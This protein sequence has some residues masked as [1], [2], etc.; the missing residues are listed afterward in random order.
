MSGNFAQK[1]R[2]DY[3]RFPATCWQCPGQTGLPAVGLQGSL[4]STQLEAPRQPDAPYTSTAHPA[5]QH[6]C[7]A[8]PT[9]LQQ[10][11]AFRTIHSPAHSHSIHSKGMNMSH[12]AYHCCWK[13]LCSSSASCWGTSHIR[14]RTTNQAKE[15]LLPFLRQNTGRQIW[16]VF[17]GITIYEIRKQMPCTFQWKKQAWI[18]LEAIKTFGQPENITSATKTVAERIWN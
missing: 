9:Q 3:L 8:V 17:Q 12:M 14:V 11:K 5:A 13:K 18:I 1:H 15:G 16:S 6:C 10:F 2:L 7:T 4:P